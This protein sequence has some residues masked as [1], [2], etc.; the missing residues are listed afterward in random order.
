[1]ESVNKK[2]WLFDIL[3]QLQT[4]NEADHFLSQTSTLIDSLFNKNIN[5]KDKMDELFP[6]DMVMSLQNAWKEAGIDTKNIIEIQHFLEE[7]KEVVKHT[8]VINVTIAFK[9]K[10]QTIRRIHAWI[11]SHIKTPLMLNIKVEKEIIGGAIIEFKGKY[12]EYTVHKA[13]NETIATLSNSQ[14]SALLEKALNN[15]KLH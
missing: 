1:M 11:A 15:G 3:F 13:L 4:K 2:T 7:L 10:E 8:P 6:S 14:R 12:F 9:P 5:V